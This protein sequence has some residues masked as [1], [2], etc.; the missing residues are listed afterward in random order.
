MLNTTLYHHNE[1]HHPILGKE[2]ILFVF[3]YYVPATKCLLIKSQLSA[4]FPKPLPTF[5]F[6]GKKKSLRKVHTMF[7]HCDQIS[8]TGNKS[9]V[10]GTAMNLEPEDTDYQFCDLRQVMSLGLNFFFKIY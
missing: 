6:G 8:R 2:E 10:I 9:F 5:Q 3:L 1:G 4:T 7:T